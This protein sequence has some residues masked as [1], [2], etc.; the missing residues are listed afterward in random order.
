MFHIFPSISLFSSSHL[1]QRD[2]ARKAETP[3]SAESDPP[4]NLVNFNGNGWW[5]WMD[6][7]WIWGNPPRDRTFKKRSP[8]KADGCSM[9]Q[10]AF[11]S[12]TWPMNCGFMSVTISNSLTIGWS[13]TTT[14][15]SG[16]F[17]LTWTNGSTLH[18]V[19]SGW[20]P[21]VKERHPAI[22]WTST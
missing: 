16:R 19:F 18:L 21:E 2:P 11:R 7:G 4:G 3:A 14:G 1:T 10:S 6:Y 15:W 17:A 22:F 8:P 9:L 20:F 13:T 12:Q 5:I